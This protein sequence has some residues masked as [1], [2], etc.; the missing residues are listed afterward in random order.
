MKKNTLFFW[1]LAI[2]PTLVFTQPKNDSI[3]VQWNYYSQRDLLKKSI[4]KPDTSKDDEQTKFDRWDWFWNNRHGNDG[5]MRTYIKGMNTFY[6]KKS[7]TTLSVNCQEDCNSS[8]YPADWRFIGPEY[9]A[10]QN[11][12]QVHALW[13]NPAISSSDN[14]LAGAESGLWKT[15][16]GGQHW[17]NL[18][19]FCLPG[20]GIFSIAVQSNN[21]NIIYIG[22]GVANSVQSTDHSYGNGI[23][24]STDGGVSWQHLTVANLVPWENFCTKILIHPFNLNLYAIIASRA[25]KSINGGATWVQIL[26]DNENPDRLTLRDIELNP[27]I[28]TSD[29]VYISSSSHVTNWF[30]C[31]VTSNPCSWFCSVSNAQYATA[32]VWKL[33]TPFNSTTVTP[34]SLQNL[35]STIPGYTNDVALAMLSLTQN[36]IN[37]ACWTNAGT[38][39]IY[40]KIGTNPWTGFTPAVTCPSGLYGFNNIYSLPFEVS[41]VNDNILYLGG[42]QLFKSTD[43]GHNL[44]CCWQYDAMNIG[45]NFLGSHPDLRTFVLYQSTAS[46]N[47]ILFLGNDGGIG[48]TANGGQSTT[49]L[50]GA[51]LQLTQVYGISNNEKYPTAIYGGTQD[52]GIFNNTA[53]TW[54]VDV[55]GDAYDA[56]SDLNDP[57]IA[58]TS[59]NGNV[60]YK[61][62][63]G[64]GSWSSLGHPPGESFVYAPLWVD[65]LNRLYVGGLNLWRRDGNSWTQITH[66]I[67]NRGI[68]SV[69]LTDDGNTAY[70]VYSGELWDANSPNS[71]F[72]GKVYKIT[73]LNTSPVATDITAFLEGV[74]YTSITDLAIDP[75]DGEKVWVCFGGMWTSDHKVYK[76]ENNSWTAFGLGLP[77]KPSNALEYMK[78][79]NDLLFIG[80]DDGVYYRNNLMTEWKP[81]MCNLPH[82]IVTDLEINYNANEL[83]AATFGRGI[84]KT[85][86][87]LQYTSTCSVPA[88]ITTNLGNMSNGQTTLVT[89]LSQSVSINYGG[90]CIGGDCCALPGGGIT[91]TIYKKMIYPAIMP[92]SNIATGTGATISFNGIFRIGQPA[93]PSQK[94]SYRV[95]IKLSCSGKDCATTNLFFNGK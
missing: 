45:T 31:P 39:K 12:G 24:K 51:N 2:L 42:N 69:K 23:Y 57:L 35:C 37:I 44:V 41:P 18:T 26:G 50:N 89:A 80:T 86:I 73:N 33:N 79:A 74:R 27:Q 22:T 84:W 75:V 30:A 9:I 64:G 7:T 63:T 67:S 5:D 25:Y 32:K 90:T 40:R 55:I 87:P 47:D 95:E 8:C 58:Y 85:K 70:I 66:L 72:Q 29:E 82:T 38:P 13:V 76:Y 83:R 14:M 48:K 94:F 91:W 68:R 1:T 93:F 15:N 71:A 16:D 17:T 54:K 34:F 77:N 19:D 53:T 21:A 52:N 65:N 81:F 20:V 92:E 36:S 49:N 43:G 10:K 6:Q 88:L 61:T 60:V 56:A 4:G 28:T 62:T 78:N 3:P 46:G 59:S 11:L